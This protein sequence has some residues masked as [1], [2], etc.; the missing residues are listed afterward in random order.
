ML[1]RISALLRHSSSANRPAALNTIRPLTTV[2]N[3]GRP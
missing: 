2:P 3:N 1:G